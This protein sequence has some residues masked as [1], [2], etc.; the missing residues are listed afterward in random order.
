MELH[1]Q[2]VQTLKLQIVFNYLHAQLKCSKKFPQK[3][4]KEHLVILNHLNS[5]LFFF[6]NFLEMVQNKKE[7]VIQSI[8]LLQ[9]KI[10]YS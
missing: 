7:E 6:E 2:E 1:S 5:T 3:E 4:G 9:V 10:N 8:L